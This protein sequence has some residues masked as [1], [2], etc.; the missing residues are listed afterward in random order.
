LLQAEEMVVTFFSQTLPCWRF[1]LK[2]E[3]LPHLYHA[4]IEPQGSGG[5]VGV[6]KSKI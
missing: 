1:N 5:G 3:L 2:A 4:I 6:G